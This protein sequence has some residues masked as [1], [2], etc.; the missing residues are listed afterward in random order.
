M[1]SDPVCLGFKFQPCCSPAGE[2][3]LPSHGEG[4][5]VMHW[6]RGSDEGAGKGLRPCSATSQS[7][8]LVASASR[9]L[10]ASVSPSIKPK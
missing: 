7:S 10:C 8:T 1:A 6:V 4:G 9:P 2:L 3:C 5:R